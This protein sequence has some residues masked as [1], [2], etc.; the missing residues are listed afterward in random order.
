M[1]QE[2][3]MTKP[4]PDWADGANHWYIK[5]LKKNTKEPFQYG[6][7]KTLKE[8]VEFGIQLMRNFKTILPITSD[9]TGQI[10]PHLYVERRNQTIG[11][12][13]W[14][15]KTD[16]AEFEPK[17]FL[18]ELIHFYLTERYPLWRSEEDIQEAIEND[19]DWN[20]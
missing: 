14:N 1:L 9:S 15:H 10:I 4:K 13:I 8:T 19:P 17:D 16:K 20:G 11:D 7:F 2:I 6:P 18:L 3:E 5:Q 12:I